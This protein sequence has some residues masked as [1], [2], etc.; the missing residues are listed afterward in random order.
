MVSGVVRITLDLFLAV[1]QNIFSWIFRNIATRTWHT[2]IIW[3]FIL[4]FD[5][6]GRLHV[7]LDSRLF[8]HHVFLSS[9][10]V[11]HL[12][13]LSIWPL[14]I[15]GQIEIQ[16]LTFEGFSF[17]AQ[18]LGFTNVDETST[19][20]LMCQLELDVLHLFFELNLLL[21]QLF[22]QSLPLFLVEGLLIGW[23]LR[24][25]HISEN[26]NLVVKGLKPIVKVWMCSFLLS[27][28]DGQLDVFR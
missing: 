19:L 21:V 13:H 14:Y 28:V 12:W 3:A 24:V 23:H 10:S 1:A 7:G 15:S 4:F 11:T 5:P 8:L 9:G 2:G 26:I 22:F 17:H 20:G 16:I 6:V 25:K 18:T 27:L